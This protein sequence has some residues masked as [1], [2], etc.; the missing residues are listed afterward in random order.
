MSSSISWT[1]TSSNPYCIGN[2]IEGTVRVLPLAARCS[3]N[4][5][6]IGNLIEV[7]MSSSISWTKTSSNPYCIGNLIEVISVYIGIVVVTVLILIVLE[8]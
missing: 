4:P 6:C 8:T 2:L 1:K 7:A 5:Y 3:S